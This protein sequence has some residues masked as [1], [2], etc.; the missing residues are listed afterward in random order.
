MAPVVTWLQSPRLLF[1]ELSERKST[2]KKTYQA[3]WKPERIE[4]ADRKCMGRYCLQSTRD[5]KS[6]QT[7]FWKIKSGQRKKRSA[8]QNDLWLRFIR[9]LILFL[10]NF[11]FLILP[12]LVFNTKTF[13]VNKLIKQD[14]KKSKQP[15]TS[16]FEQMEI[17]SLPLFFNFLKKNNI[18]SP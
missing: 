2:W 15:L 4:Q 16:T 5:S 14:K 3:V 6:N 1:L 8:Y 18:S 17:K 12:V 9:T 7:V 11:K 10:Y 13:C